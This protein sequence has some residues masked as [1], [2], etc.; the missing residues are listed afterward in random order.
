MV[1]EIRIP[2]MLRCWGWWLGVRAA[3]KVEEGEEGEKGQERESVKKVE[4]NMTKMG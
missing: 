4:V 1:T 2:G 3:R